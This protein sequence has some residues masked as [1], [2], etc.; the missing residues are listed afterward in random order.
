MDGYF[1]SLL[2]C[3][4][5]RPSH[6]LAASFVLPVGLMSSIPLRRDYRDPH[7]GLGVNLSSLSAA[8]ATSFLVH[9]CGAL[10]YPDWNHRNIV[11]PYW[12][13]HHNST[14]G[15]AISCDGREYPLRPDTAV[16]TPAGVR[17]DTLGRRTVPHLWIHYT[18]LQEF[19]LQIKQPVSISVDTALSETLNAIRR[20]L[21][22]E[23]ISKADAQRKLHHFC[24]SSLH[25]G[26]AA[27]EPEAFR[28]FPRRMH[29]LLEHIERNLGKDLSTASLAQLSGLSADGFSR[30]F[31]RHVGETPS[32]YV[33][34]TRMRA[35]VKHL[36][37]SDDTIEQV[38][39]SLGYP[40]R[41]YFSRVFR[42][43]LGCGP[44]TFR[45]GARLADATAT[46]TTS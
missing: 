38:A 31:R 22:S 40:N 41:F 10:D 33:T 27:L 29:H 37:L 2:L 12:R 7:T 4:F 9:E 46:A 1:K 8:G 17:I 5:F 18:P 42:K 25:L 13:L 36:T 24:K 14:S 32:R 30:W 43:N 28:A 23:A 39:D 3:I 19:V 15:N 6:L 16:L 20:T 34:S 26:F 44:A 11:S 35:A 21:D 45:R